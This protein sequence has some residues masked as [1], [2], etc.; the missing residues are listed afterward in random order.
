MEVQSIGSVSTLVPD[1]PQVAQQQRA[2]GEAQPQEAPRAAAPAQGAAPA[3]QGAAQ[4]ANETRGPLVAAD[5]G[6]A[7]D[8][9]QQ[10]KERGG[11]VDEL[12]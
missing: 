7:E 4:Q 3:G 2:N 11:L 8:T 6:R 10:P 1:R 12:A 9:Q 5:A